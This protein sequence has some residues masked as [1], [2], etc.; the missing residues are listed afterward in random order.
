MF[1]G[2]LAPLRFLG[3]DPGGPRW[4]LLVLETEALLIRPPATG[5]FAAWSSLRGQSRAFLE[6]WE[7]LW[8]GDDLT[9]TSYRRRLKRYAQEI[10]Q[11]EAYPFFVFLKGG[12]TL[13]GGLTLGNI[14]R[15]AS[16]TGTLGYWM[17]APHA[18]KGLMTE[19]VREVCRLGFVHLKLARIEAAC[20]EDN[21]GSIRLLEKTG[22]RREGLARSYL[23]IAGRRRDHLLFARL[24]G[25]PDGMTA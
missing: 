18:G 15:G 24:P 19:A 12:A 3:V 9:Q 4:P 11:D 25:D 13:V 20:L 7:P 21:A 2:R 22:F 14:R 16:R 23:E 8:P 10:E 6:P 17:G 1:A 5:D